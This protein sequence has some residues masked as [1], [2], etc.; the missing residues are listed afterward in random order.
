MIR[1]K[2]TDPQ[3]LACMFWLQWF[4]VFEL[5]KMSFLAQW[6]TFTNG[7]VFVLPWYRIH[8]LGYSYSRE[9]REAKHWNKILL[10]FI[11]I[12]TFTMK[13]SKW[14]TKCICEH[15][16]TSAKRTEHFRW[17]KCFHRA[18]VLAYY[19]HQSGVSKP[20][21]SVSRLYKQDK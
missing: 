18:T 15:L 21:S 20:H 12:M 7:G 8:L 14:S 17:L 2:T 19:V 16:K 13:W 10:N 5:Y 4:L 1:D 3:L 6:T 11:A 9:V